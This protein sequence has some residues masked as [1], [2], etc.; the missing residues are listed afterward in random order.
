LD[1]DYIKEIHSSGFNRISLGIQDFS[2]D[3]LQ[4]VNRE[5]PDIPVVDIVK[6]L[7]EK[8]DM[9]INLDFIYGLPLQSTESFNENIE[10]AIE[11]NPDR[12]VTFSY[13]HVPWVKPAQMKLEKLGLPGSEEKLNM[14]DTASNRLIKSG[15]R[16]IGLDHFAKPDD[17][18]YLA[19]QNR[20]LHRN[21]QGYCTKE[22]TGQV[23]AAG[24]SSISQL[25]EAYIQNTKNVKDYMQSLRQG[26]FAQEK[27]YVLND[28]E[29]IVRNIINELMCNL[30]LDIENIA[31]NEGLSISELERIVS[32]DKAMLEEFIDDDLIMWDE[33]RLEVKPPGKYFLRNIASAFDPMTGESNKK[34]SKTI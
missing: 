5:I 19:L 34:F 13:A 6:W 22:S 14:F 33:K 20:V 3:V 16:S 10:K 4:A 32:P 29:K 26:N 1:E 30:Y 17:E 9:K 27:Y 25:N 28:N 12:M 2:T 31:Q 15:Y 21:F 7:R 18:L 23:Y 8:E 11:I 24:V